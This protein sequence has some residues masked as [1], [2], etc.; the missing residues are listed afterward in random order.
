MTSPTWLPQQ[1]QAIADE[2]SVHQ[3]FVTLNVMNHGERISLDSIPSDWTIELR[4]LGTKKPQSIHASHP[5]TGVTWKIAKPGAG[6]I[7]IGEEVRVVHIEPRA[8]S[9]VFI[10]LQGRRNHLYLE[11]GNYQ[12][13]GSMDKGE[14]QVPYDV[15]VRAAASPVVINS[16]ARIRSLEGV[17]KVD[18]HSTTNSMKL[19]LEGNLIARQP[20][21]NVS[22]SI[23]GTL[24][25]RRGLS[26]EGDLDVTDNLQVELDL[27][28]TG[29]YRAASIDVS[30]SAIGANRPLVL[31]ASRGINIGQSLNN[32]ILRCSGA[33]SVVAI[34]LAKGTQYSLTDPAVAAESIAISQV[35][36]SSPIR[37]PRAKTSRCLIFGAGDVKIGTTLQNSSAYAGRRLEVG[38]D[39]EATADTAQ[40][41]RDHLPSELSDQEWAK[42]STPYTYG[43]MV[44]VANNVLLS[45]QAVIVF[46]KFFSCKQLSNGTVRQDSN[47]GL[48][49]VNAATNAVIEASIVGIA[50]DCRDSCVTAKSSLQVNGE[51][52]ESNFSSDGRIFFEKYVNGRIHWTPSG[53]HH[54]SILF[55]ARQLTINS[56][57]EDATVS[58]QIS[59]NIDEFIVDGTCAVHIEPNPKVRVSLNQSVEI[60]KHLTLRDKAHVNIKLD[61]SHSIGRVLLGQNS[62]ITQRRG[63]IYLNVSMDEEPTSL[64]LELDAGTITSVDSITEIVLGKLP[65]M[66]I[67]S[68]N[69]TLLGI[70]NEVS[71]EPPTAAANSKVP[72]ISLLEGGR[73]ESLSGRFRLADLN[74]SRISGA[75]AVAGSKLAPVLVDV[76]SSEESL[77]G[78]ELVS[79][80]VTRL[81]GTGIR[82]LSHLHV[83]EPDRTSLM[84][85]AQENVG[86]LERRDRSQRLKIL[87]DSVADKALSGTVRSAVLWSSARAHHSAVGGR[88][89]VEFAFRSLHR[90]VGYGFRPGPALLTYF[91]WIAALAGVLT[92]FDSCP[93]CASPDPSSG[94]GSGNRVSYIPG[95]YNYWEQLARLV[96][97]P[98]GLLRLEMGGAAT[99]AP[100]ACNAGLHALVFAITG[101]I[102]IYV[103]LAFRN[104]LRTPKEM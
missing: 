25:C 62:K 18:L 21:S 76:T 45:K 31:T 35:V 14:G 23:K 95:P 28:G 46:N 103:A 29:R 93:V 8:T 58:V 50:E 94:E 11:S 32:A 7:T 30:G 56:R 2:S 40:I 68:G 100:I 12:I 24:I 43:L 49:A 53:A 60:I 26:G 85:Y 83:F 80:N 104:Y 86:P 78:G 51:N 73:I 10:H 97:L 99:Y 47:D 88:H 66:R 64:I 44:L 39:I 33:E 101:L 61:R 91:V 87:V 48:V 72:I 4:G 74:A 102:L 96:L 57:H 42:S 75:N 19:K 1:L 82:M 27:S 55:G 54:C 81:S 89:Y 70:F 22:G 67:V 92:F 90:L 63:S 52:G 84:L 34:G 36:S 13:E 41:L 77:S 65:K 98:A 3:R 5:G 15:K 69:I 20:I 17:G 37:G 16:T 6:R 9:T 79:V 59:D 38:G 71:I